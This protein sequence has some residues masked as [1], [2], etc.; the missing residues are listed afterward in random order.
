[1]YKRIIGVV[2]VDN[3]IVCR[4]RNFACDYLYTDAFIDTN[5]FDEIV[6]IDVSKNRS[7]ETLNL[8]FTTIEKLMSKSQ[9]PMAIGGGISS[10]NDILRYREFGADRY[11]INQ[12]S[13]TSD[14]FVKNAIEKFG[15]S[16]IISGIDHWQEF[17]FENGK[18]TET[19]LDERVNSIFD[20]S[21]SEILLNSAALD[22]SLT[23]FDLNVVQQI[24]DS[25]K[26]PIIISGGV[27]R[28]THA[29]NALEIEN[30]TGICTSNIYHLTTSTILSW[31]KQI[32]EN[33]GNVR[34]L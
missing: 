20:N 6:F 8:F 1:M 5:F 21:G 34:E 23:G 31:R 29:L 26:I 16:S 24:S 7:N 9:L 4:T 22:G 32:I 25:Y 10:I 15:K 14:E 3:G 33:S 27:G 28:W 12:T 17:T 18:K 11:I 2:L 30:V 13:S 19:K